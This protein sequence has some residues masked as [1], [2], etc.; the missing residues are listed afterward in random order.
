MNSRFDRL[1]VEDLTV[2]IGLLACYLLVVGFVQYFAW[3]RKSK[4]SLKVTVALGVLAA[5]AFISWDLQ[6][7]SGNDVAA[8]I[9]KSVYVLCSFGSLLVL[10]GDVARLIV[11][12]FRGS[13][14]S[15]RDRIR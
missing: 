5:V 9:A 15:G 8:R 1:F 12:G 11:R 14:V 6:A 7:T 13:D 4:S 3:R 2:A 10:V